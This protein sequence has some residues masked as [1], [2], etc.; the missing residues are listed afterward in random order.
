MSKLQPGTEL[1]MN[2]V[3]LRIS[4]DVTGLVGFAKDFQTCD[5]FMDA[6][7]D[8]LFEIIKLSESLS[9]PCPSRSLRPASPDEVCRDV[10]IVAA[11]AVSIGPIVSVSY[12]PQK[13]ACSEPDTLQASHCC[14]L[15]PWSV[16][17]AFRELYSRTSNPARKFW[18]YSLWSPE[19]RRVER[20]FKQFRLRMSQLLQEVCS[21]LKCTYHH[22]LAAFLC[23]SV[24]WPSAPVC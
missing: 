20:L 22:V 15:T 21:L 5:T 13:I 3:T 24:S 8:E 19:R 17:A 10:L 2:N 1:D 11:A 4:L 23:M 12:T 18:I 6:G 9:R 14:Q 16:H 7:T